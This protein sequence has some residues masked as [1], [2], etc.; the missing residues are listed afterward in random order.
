MGYIQPLALQESIVLSDALIAAAN[1]ERAQ[2]STTYVLCKSILRLTEIY[3]TSQIRVKHDM[4]TLAGGGYSKL[5]KNG[6]AIPGT[7][8][9]N[10][11]GSY[12]TYTDDLSITD[13][14]AGDTLE[15]WVY[16]TSPT[17]TNTYVRNFQIYGNNVAFS[18][19]I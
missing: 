7:E 19:S 4:R 1:T 5:Y 15:V 16:N 18:E 6:Q 13:F 10:G 14:K 2:A 9:Y 17:P 11:S 3:H 12:V 8:H